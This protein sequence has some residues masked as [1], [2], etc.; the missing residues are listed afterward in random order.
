MWSW[1][2]LSNSISIKP[3]INGLKCVP[4]TNCDAG[5]FV[6]IDIGV[7][8]FMPLVESYFESYPYQDSMNIPGQL[9]YEPTLGGY[10]FYNASNS[11]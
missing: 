4:N 9:E 1:T 7:N 8:I 3:S 5:I 2:F 6:G 11:K 10:K